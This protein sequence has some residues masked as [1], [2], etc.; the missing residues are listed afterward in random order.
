[1]S[2]KRVLQVCSAGRLKQ[3]DFLSK[4][5]KWTKWFPKMPR[6]WIILQCDFGFLVYSFSCSELTSWFTIERQ[7]LKPNDCSTIPQAPCWV[8][9]TWLSKLRRVKNFT[10][11]ARVRHAPPFLN[12]LPETFLLYRELFPPPKLQKSRSHVRSIPIVSPTNASKPRDYFYKPLRSH[13]DWSSFLKLKWNSR[14]E[15]YT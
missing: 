8:I 10:M 9:C 12:T 11:V 7:I 1:M 14:K 5:D 13:F 2:N 3:Q 4:M 15:F 6:H